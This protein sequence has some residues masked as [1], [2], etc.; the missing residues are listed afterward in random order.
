MESHRQEEDARALFAA[1]FNAISGSSGT[2]GAADRRMR[3]VLDVAF[4]R[5]LVRLDAAPD[6]E[7]A[8]V[9]ARSDYE[10]MKLIS[11]RLDWVPHPSVGYA[12]LMALGGQNADA[13]N[14]WKAMRKPEAETPEVLVP[15]LRDSAP[16]PENL[17]YLRRL[18]DF[19]ERIIKET[20]AGDGRSGAGKNCGG[21]RVRPAR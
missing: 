9:A 14:T 3:E 8:Q 18:R 21:N 19:L 11:L 20:S 15:V 1:L 17:P 6:D 5:L 16:F 4:G 13:A 2:I 10:H 12:V 7:R